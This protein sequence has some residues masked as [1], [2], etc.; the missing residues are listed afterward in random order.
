MGIKQCRK[1]GK[2]YHEKE[3]FNWSCRTH[4]SDFGEE[5]KIWWCCGKQGKETPGC[6]YSKHECKEDDEDEEDDQEKEKNKAK[7]LK[8]IRCQ[9]CKEMGHGIEEC[10]N[11]PNLKTY[12]EN[13]YE[14][15]N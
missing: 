13:N 6:Q 10:P 15:I 12:K 14:M 9:C 3:N 1:C 7:H 2:E 5:D 8:Y 4:R 11:D